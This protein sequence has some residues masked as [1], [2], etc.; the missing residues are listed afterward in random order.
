MLRGQWTPYPKYLPPKRGWYLTTIYEIETKET[1]QHVT[2]WSGSKFKL[3]EKYL[4]FAF[5]NLGECYHIHEG[6]IIEELRRLDHA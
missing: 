4:I 6:R 3:S 2:W 1:R 5:R